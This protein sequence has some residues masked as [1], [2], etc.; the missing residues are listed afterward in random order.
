[1]LLWT[2]CMNFCVG[3]M[4]N[5][6]IFMKTAG[7][8]MERNVSYF[9]STEPK[10]LRAE[11]TGMMWTNLLRECRGVLLCSGHRHPPGATRSPTASGTRCH[12]RAAKQKESL[13]P[14]PDTPLKW[15]QNPLMPK[16]VSRQVRFLI[17]FPFMWY[18]HHF[19]PDEKNRCRKVD[20]RYT[21]VILASWGAITKANLAS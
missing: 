3:C 8:S 19:P 1:M 11:A 16:Q 14:N 12:S 21:P 6:S 17:I 5:I 13:Q 9:V 18:E 4:K 10:V 7:F 20:Y 15:S 2:P